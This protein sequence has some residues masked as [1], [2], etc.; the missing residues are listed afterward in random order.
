MAAA[1]LRLG[2]TLPS[3]RRLLKTDARSTEGSAL[4]RGQIVAEGF[5]FGG[6]ESVEAAR[7]VLAKER[8]VRIS[9]ILWVN[10][11]FDQMKQI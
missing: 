2:T 4:R 3:V 5:D 1:R 7:V 8:F 6:M 9:S 11:C 10:S